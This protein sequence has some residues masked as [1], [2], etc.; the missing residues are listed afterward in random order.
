MQE[1]SRVSVVRGMLCGSQLC[2]DWDND[3]L[4]T[5]HYCGLLLRLSLSSSFMQLGNYYI[6]VGIL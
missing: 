4:L 3:I 2:D 1:Q 5:L 6:L